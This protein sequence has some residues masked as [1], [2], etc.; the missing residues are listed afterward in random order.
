MA[1]FPYIILSQVRL[2]HLLL[3]MR[4]DMP[5]QTVKTQ[6]RLLQGAVRSGSVLFVNQIN[7]FYDATKHLVQHNLCWLHIHRLK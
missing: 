4:T 1:H 2:N 6:I 3:D 5:Y 7:S